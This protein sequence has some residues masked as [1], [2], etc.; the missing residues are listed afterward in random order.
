MT[1][2]PSSLLAQLESVSNLPQLQATCW[3]QGRQ[4]LRHGRNGMAPSSAQAMPPYM[5]EG[6][7]DLSYG[8]DGFTLPVRNDVLENCSFKSAAHEPIQPSQQDGFDASDS[9]CFIVPAV[10]G[11]GCGPI[12]TAAG[13]NCYYPLLSSRGNGGPE[14]IGTF[15]RIFPRVASRI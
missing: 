10:P 8:S 6:N 11:D 5:A 7:Q 9:N 13:G 1:S 12:I 15:P 3:P 4:H 14:Q 2:P